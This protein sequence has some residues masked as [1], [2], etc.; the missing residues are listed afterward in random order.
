M[1]GQEALQ[2]SSLVRRF[3]GFP[4]A[5]RF[6][7]AE[8]QVDELLRYGLP[9]RPDADLQPLARQAWDHAFGKEMRLKPFMMSHDLLKA[10]DYRL[11]PR[12]L[13]TLSAAQTRF[14][15]S[16]NW[17]GAYVAANHSQH[18]LQI[19]GLWTIPD[20]LRPPPPPFSGDPGKDYK[21]ATWVGL[22]GQRRY[23]DSSLPQVGTTSILQPDGTRW[24][25]AWVQWWARD[26]LSLKLIP[27]TLKV[28]PGQPVLC[29]LTVQGPQEVV[30]V[31]INCGVVPFTAQAV[32]VCPP[33]AKVSGGSARPSI[34]GATAEWVVERPRDVNA[35]RFENFPNY[36]YT[37]FDFCVAVEG[38]ALN[39]QSVQQGLPM[40]LQGAR[41]IRMF[42]TLTGPARTRYISI[43]YKTNNTTLNVRYGRF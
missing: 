43:P 7:P 18:L 23:F 4:G 15:N 26:E 22:D 35:D 5:E 19:W 8:A 25:Q 28:Q 33:F 20:G 16:S 12:H 40:E 9:P 38:N 37:Q 24:A 21:V 10:V 3:T 2:A 29:V 32:Q 41:E 30:C 6:N 39:L 1:T 11:L 42:Q 36:G 27:M 17:S 31:V 13:E 34:A 14:E